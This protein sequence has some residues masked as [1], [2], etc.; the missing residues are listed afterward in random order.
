MYSNSQYIN[1]LL[2]NNSNVC[3]KSTFVNHAVTREPTELEF[4]LAFIW[5]VPSV[6]NKWLLLFQ[7][8]HWIGVQI[9]STQ[10]KHFWKW[11]YWELNA[12]RRIAKCTILREQVW[13]KFR[14]LSHCHW[15]KTN[16]LVCYWKHMCMASFM[17]SNVM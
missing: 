8:G 17:I 5:H 13:T 11:E 15:V 14:H 12:C 16:Y 7:E 6:R 4:K 9:N 3:G 10:R 1:H 2:N